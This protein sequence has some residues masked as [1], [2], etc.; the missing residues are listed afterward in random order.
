VKIGSLFTGYG[1]LDS[2]ARAVF[3]GELAWVCDNH[4][5]AVKLLQHRH[6]DVPNLGDITA[7]DWEQVELVDLLAAGFPCTDI[8]NAGERA[9][10]EGTHSGLWSHVVDAIRVLRPRHVVLENVSA[11]LV[12]GL[13]RVVADLAALGYDLRWTCLRAADIGAPHRRDRWFGLAVPSVARGATPNSAGNG[14]DEGRAQSAGIV[15]GSD[16]AVGGAPAADTGCDPRQEDDQDRASPTGRGGEP[17]ANTNVRR[18]GE[19]EP[20]LRWRQPDA[21][22]C[23]VADADCDG[24]REQSVAECWSG[25]EAV[26][27]QSGPD[28]DWGQ[29]EPAIRRW[30]SI[31]GRTAPEPTVLGRNGG[32]V[33]SPWFVEWLMGLPAGW[34]TDVPGLSRSQMLRLLGNGVV[35]QQGIAALRWLCSFEA[36]YA[37]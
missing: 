35:P 22:R 31:L 11:L 19:V 3:G 10:I 6:P 15:R 5:S 18:R 21:D 23:V 12:R 16:V 13:D 26:A 7:V 2:A 20:E 30:E 25:S 24:V 29:F 1:G 32:P 27:V 28:V 8:S 37:A 14:W 34:V 17:A 36:R 9:G 4:P 33:L